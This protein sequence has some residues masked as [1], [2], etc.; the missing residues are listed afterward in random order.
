MDRVD[1]EDPRRK[2]SCSKL[3]AQAPGQVRDPRHDV[4][5]R[6]RQLRGSTRAWDRRRASASGFCFD[7]PKL[8]CSL[9]RSL[10]GQPRP[11]P[12]RG[13]EFVE[14]PFMT[15]AANSDGGGEEAR[16]RGRTACAA[17]ALSPATP[18]HAGATAFASR[19]RPHL[20][21]LRVELAA[22]RKMSMAVA[23][24]DDVATG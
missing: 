21:T 11:L 14:L 23:H 16:I 22:R 3:A 20:G 7:R 6:S 5:Q 1:E 8:Q 17:C 19:L 18:M 2:P 10:H 9:S 24:A 13:S 15:R 4:A 12:A